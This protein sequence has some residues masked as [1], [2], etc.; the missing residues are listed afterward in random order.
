VTL[1][2]V[3]AGARD[4]YAEIGIA[5]VRVDVLEYFRG[6]L[7]EFKDDPAVLTRHILKFGDKTFT[8]FN[9]NLE[10][11]REYELLYDKRDFS[12]WKIVEVKEMPDEKV[13]DFGFG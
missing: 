8:C 13:R 11:G 2:K 5:K 9:V 12:I 1:E 3:L 4:G 7:D 6:R 10:V